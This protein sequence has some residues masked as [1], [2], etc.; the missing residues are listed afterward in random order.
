M[1]QVVTA[2]FEVQ[3]PEIVFDIREVLAMPHQGSTRG[4]IFNYSIASSIQNSW[5]Y[6][7][8][9]YPLFMAGAKP[10]DCAKPNSLKNL[11]NI[12]V[13]SSPALGTIR[14]KHLRAASE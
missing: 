13:G 12:Q 14:E 8:I 11:S 1:C 3:K 7:L 2:D 6:D 5:G 9:P 4:G 10:G